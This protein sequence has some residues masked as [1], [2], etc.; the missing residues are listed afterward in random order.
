MYDEPPYEWPFDEPR[1]ERVEEKYMPIVH[2]CLINVRV[3]IYSYIHAHTFDWT[4]RR[5]S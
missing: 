5:G 4:Q 3:C 2:S 1:Y